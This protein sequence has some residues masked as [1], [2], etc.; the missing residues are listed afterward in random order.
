MTNENE[1]KKFMAPLIENGESLSQVQQ[2]VNE[3]FSTKYTYMEI[4]ILASTLDEID[5][6]KFDPKPAA[7]KEEKKP[8]ADPAM[9]DAASPAAGEAAPAA[10]K[11]KIE[12]SKIARPGMAI[13]GSVVFASGATA[14]WFVDRMGRLSL[15][16]VNGKPTEEDAIAFQDE[17][18]A[19]LSR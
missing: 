10:G 14:D 2:M 18:Q 19:M 16:N 4:R 11:T 8:A 13:S 1:I 5:W 6:G 3:K 17:L 12:I 7:P 15:D 9:A